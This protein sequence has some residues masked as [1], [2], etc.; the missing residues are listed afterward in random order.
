[1]YNNRSIFLCTFYFSIDI[2]TKKI[3]SVITRKVEGVVAK[4]KD[5]DALKLDDYAVKSAYKKLNT[6]EKKWWVQK[7][8]I[9]K[10]L[11]QSYVD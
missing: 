8:E 1:V 9:E 5:I 4:G 2:G 11:G 6:K 3:R 10:Y 7:V